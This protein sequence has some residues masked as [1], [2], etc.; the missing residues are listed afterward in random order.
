MP[1]YMEILFWYLF[2]MNIVSVIITVHDKNSAVK[3]RWRVPEKTLLTVGALSGCIVMYSTM[4]IIHH[5]T[6]HKKFMIG[7]PLI[8]VFELA[9]F[10][11]ILYFSGNIN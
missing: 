8:F 9:A 4:K 1:F 11:M 7:L 10:V 6:M 5:K 3:H 2:I